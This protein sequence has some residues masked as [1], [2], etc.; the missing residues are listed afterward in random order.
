MLLCFFRLRRLFWLHSACLCAAPGKIKAIPL[1]AHGPRDDAVNGR[2][3]Y[4]HDPEF[5]RK[6]SRFYDLSLPGQAVVYPG[7]GFPSERQ[8]GYVSRRELLVVGIEF[9]VRSRRQ[10]ELC[11][12]CTTNQHRD[13]TKRE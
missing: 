3:E 10:L 9:D 13:E 5:C 8:H 6:L 7:R 2:P 11:R 12:S 4:G 1:E